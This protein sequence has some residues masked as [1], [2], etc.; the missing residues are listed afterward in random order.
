MPSSRATS[1][2]AT[3]DAPD[4]PAWLAGLSDDALVRVCELRPDVATPP[5][6]SLDVLA[7]RAEAAKDS[8]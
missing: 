3:A 1:R 7:S 8:G 6:A 4:F 5:P 2:G